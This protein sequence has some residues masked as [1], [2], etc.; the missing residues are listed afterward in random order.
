MLSYNSRYTYSI[1]NSPSTP[2]P[3]CTLYS[4]PHSEYV[5]RAMH[6]FITSTYM[7]HMHCT[8]QQ[9]QGPLHEPQLRMRCI[10]RISKVA[11][12]THALHARRDAACHAYI[13]SDYAYA[14][15]E[16]AISIYTQGAM[17]HR[18]QCTAQSAEA[19]YTIR[20]CRTRV[21]AMAAMPHRASWM[22]VVRT[23]AVCFLLLAPYRSTVVASLKTCRHVL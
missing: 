9:P 17:H 20:R 4:I 8:P 19:Q 13:C 11:L 16:R 15:H 14:W 12:G 10:I 3:P 6:H 7:A 21:A 2:P 18:A 1:T 23:L 5:H 22:K